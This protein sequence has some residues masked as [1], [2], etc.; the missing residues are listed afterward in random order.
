V[1]ERLAGGRLTSGVVRVGDT[2][3]RP[4]TGASPFVVGLLAHLAAQGY[5]ACPW[6]YGQDG[7]GRDVLSFIPG[8]VAGRW[9]HFPDEDIAAVATMLRGLHDAGVGFAGTGF[10]RELHSGYSGPDAVVCHHDPGPNNVV[11]AGGRP[12]AFIDFDFAAP[13]HR[14]EDVGYLA[15]SWCISS[16]PDRGPAQA[17]GRQLRVLADAYGLDAAGRMRV[18]AAVRARLIRNLAFWRRRLGRPWTGNGAGPAE[19]IEWT[20]RELAFV[21]RYRDELAL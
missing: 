16:K 9:R 5:D 1:E 4:A 19:V 18:P 7:A 14:L 20:R 11:F 3:R 6:A 13:G 21:V 17:Q 12:V 15:W 8:E 2:V 10:S